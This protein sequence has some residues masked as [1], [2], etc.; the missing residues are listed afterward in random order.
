[1]ATAKDKSIN[2]RAHTSLPVIA[3]S[4]LAGTA[5]EWYDF[6]LYGTAAAL[7]FN[8]LFF[9]SEDPLVGTM[10]AFATYAVGF[11][12]RPLGA[13]V[14]GHFG[15]VKGRRATLIA[16]LLLMGVSTFLIALL[17]TYAA[18]GVTAPLLLVLLRLVQ[19]FALGGEWGGAVLLVSEH[20]DSKRRAFWS[21]WPNL[22]PPLGNLMA[23]GALA[24][25]GAVLPE[26][27]FL[28]WGWR[29]AFGM[30]ALLVVIGLV[31]RLYVAETP[32]F[33]QTRA[34]TSPAVLRM[35][36]TAAVRG[37]WRQILL[38]A[39]TRFGENA[40]FYIFSLFVITYLTQIL[41]LPRSTGLNA[42]MIGMVVAL[43]AIP[44]FAVLA[45]RI[46]RRPIYIGAS[47]ATIVWAFAFF[48]LL[49]TEATGAIFLAVAV[50]LVIFA[51]YSAV[52]GAFFSEL[53]PTEVRYSG[54]SLA[55]NLASVLAG[56]LAPIIA[57]E[58]YDRFGS[59]QAIGA[60][61]ALMG[62]ISLVAALVAKETRTVDLA[63]VQEEAPATGTAT[64]AAVVIP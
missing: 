23:A 13:A 59:G 11:V 8:K 30:S 28:S 2:R 51:A 32:L 63:D 4:S 62:V 54:V 49:D 53:F 27:A 37:Y 10:L 61:L 48:A 64:D 40:G 57:I 14:L 41:D 24:L 43:V 29:V 17:P 7:V 58:L 35:P 47:I 20:G 52:I 50:G 5:V 44:L 39:F 22:G 60:Y 26:E 21:A 46:G 36:L 16:S 3:G 15:D 19:G 31:L 33:E 9:P 12:A 18:I 56:S 34:A 6:F 38:A 1:M 25:L 42:V 55:Y 45:D